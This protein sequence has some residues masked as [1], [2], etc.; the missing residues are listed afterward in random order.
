MKKSILKDDKPDAQYQAIFG[1][2]SRIVDTARQSAAQSV[3]AVMTAAYWMIGRRIVEFEQSGEKRAEYG[4]ALIKRLETDLTQRFGRGFSRQNIQ[5][6]RLFY[7]SYP[8]DQIL[9]TLSGESDQSPQQAICQT[10]SG[11]SD[12]TSTEVHLEQLLEVFPLP[13][14]AYVRLLSVKNMRARDFYETE[15]LRGGWSV[16]QLD[17][18]I[19][20][21]FYERTALSKNKAAM[22]TR[23][24]KARPE[25][26]VLPEEEIKD[27]FVLEFLDLKDEYSESDLEEALID[28]LETFLLELG[29]DFCFMG[30]QRRLR[31]GDEWYRVDL[32]FF[33]RRLRCLVVIDLKI[34]KFTHADAGQMHLYLNYAR[35]H[36]MHEDENPPVG[37]ILCSQKD[38]AVARYALDGLPNKVMAA[39][40][41]TALP[42]EATLAAEI[43]RTRQVINVR[44]TGRAGLP[45]ARAEVTVENPKRGT[46]TRA[47]RP[48]GK[49]GKG[50]E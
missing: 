24:R 4:T 13:W 49:A 6:M 15:A 25:D 45:T 32:L 20:S 37:L 43:D 23:G 46:K 33:H 28:H 27:P 36:W 38:E 26:S 21:Q 12:T 14:S 10:V 16:R 34:G 9:Q 19:N 31:V 1:D 50:K 35:E 30:R 48:R 47:K 2:V 44:A 17:R 8:S 29:G 7:L 11:K 39:E 42:D 18:Q 5:Q 3:N 22:L 41:K 40:Y